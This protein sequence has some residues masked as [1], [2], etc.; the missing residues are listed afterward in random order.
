[1]SA[2]A[3]QRPLAVM[4]SPAVSLLGVF[5]VRADGA[6]D[7]AR[8]P[9]LVDRDGFEEA[10]F[11]GFDN[12]LEIFGPTS[13]GRDF[14]GA[15]FNTAIYSLASVAVILPLSVGARP[16]RLPAAGEGRRQRSA[17]FYF[18]PTWRR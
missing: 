9:G 15:L 12:F 11:V 4:L 3:S 10:R 14:K 18:R 2:L 17:R 13:V 8:L 6:D 1:M 16:P 7:L 5:V